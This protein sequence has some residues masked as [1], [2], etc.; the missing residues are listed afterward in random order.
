MING[1]MC[2][3]AKGYTKD[4]THNFQKQKLSKTKLACI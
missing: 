2:K 1:Y 4:K 3:N